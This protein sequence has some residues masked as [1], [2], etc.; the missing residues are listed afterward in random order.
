MERPGLLFR[1]LEDKSKRGEMVA[2]YI[3]RSNGI[4]NVDISIDS[5]F[6]ICA[7]FNNFYKSMYYDCILQFQPIWFRSYERWKDA[8]KE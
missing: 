7:V 5:A 6:D 8:D 2:D 3:K 4:A 1:V